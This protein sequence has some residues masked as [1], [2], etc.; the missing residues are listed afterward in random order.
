MVH[1]QNSSLIRKKTLKYGSMIVLRPKIAHFFDGAS[2]NCLGEGKKYG[3]YFEDPT[4][5]N[6]CFFK[7]NSMFH[8]YNPMIFIKKC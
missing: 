4:L 6:K 7:R 2:T 3:N 5:Q 8:M 1:I